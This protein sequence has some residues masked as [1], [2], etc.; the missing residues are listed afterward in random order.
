VS[1]VTFKKLR[2]VYP[3]GSLLGYEPQFLAI[4]QNRTPDGALHIDVLLGRELRADL[5]IGSRTGL[6]ALA[7]LVV[8]S[9][10]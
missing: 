9:S 7:A 2:I 10:F 3:P 4:F 1:F 8:K 5:I 6:K